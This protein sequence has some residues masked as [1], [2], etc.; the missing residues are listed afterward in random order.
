MRIVHV[1]TGREFRGGQRQALL[2]AQ[3]L[4]GRGYSQMILGRALGEEAARRG[5]P[6]IRLS[7]LGLAREVRRA[8]LIHAHD[9]RAHT[10]AAPAARGR[11]LVVSRRVAFPVRA[12][13]LS[14]W[15]YDRA[16]RFVAVSEF[17]K[18][19]LLEAGVQP[20]RVSVV[21]DGV[22]LPAAAAVARQP[23]VLAPETDDP[24]KGSAL[25]IEACRAAGVELR[26]SR[27]LESDLPRTSLFLYL[28]HSE[29]SA[30]PSCWRWPAGPR[31]WRAVW[32]AFPRSSST[33]K[34]GCWSRTRRP[35][36]LPPY[37]RCSPIQVLPQRVLRPP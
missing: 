11:P 4:A 7:A 37:A 25:A 23:F 14:R 6:A 28:T 31:S 36:S 3:G 18:G 15:K 35:P 26:F 17:V 13:V 2:L 33:S 16:T 30:R 5:L 29:A 1:D 24:Q 32:E 10:L 9:A 20:D 22:E 21:Y 12:G 34:P 27:D 8:D 19:T